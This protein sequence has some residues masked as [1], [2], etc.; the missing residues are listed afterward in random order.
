MTYLIAQLWL[1]LLFALLLG[2][3]LGWMLRGGCKKPL[4]TI[5][6]WQIKYARLEK[7]N[8]L[9][10]EKTKKLDKIL[11]EK[12]TLLSQ[13]SLVEKRKESLAEKLNDVQQGVGNIRTV[14]GRMK[15]KLKETNEKLKAE[16][17]NVQAKDVD[18]KKIKMEA[19]ATEHLLMKCQ[20]EWDAKHR[21]LR[22][23]WDVS[24]LKMTAAQETLQGAKVKLGD[25]EE[26][27]TELKTIVRV[28]QR[29]IEESMEETAQKRTEIE[30]KTNELNVL[31]SQ[32]QQADEQLVEVKVKTKEIDR[33]TEQVQYAEHETSIINLQF[34]DF[35][36]QAKSFIESVAGKN[37]KYKAT[38]G[39]LE[40]DI[41][42][43]KQKIKAQEFELLGTNAE[44]EMMESTISSLRDEIT[45]V[46]DSPED[47]TERNVSETGSHSETDFEP[48]SSEGEQVDKDVGRDGVNLKNEPI[49][50][51]LDAGNKTNMLARWKQIKRSKF[52][53]RPR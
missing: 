32:L 46:R 17:R 38:I 51:T 1:Y 53:R 24:Q 22:S 52:R 43:G 27:N 11:R 50:L 30:L 28:M 45:T 6:E 23:Q 18:L 34:N 48:T 41:E 10:K 14:Y 3:F 15:T 40:E 16:K 49:P 4:A 42:Q 9:S 25:S 20:D 31:T 26:E 36:E 33:L 13:A 2:S 35:K 29:Q 5:L 8:S 44:V 21:L 39:S 7:E 19:S 47:Y 37:K 12:N